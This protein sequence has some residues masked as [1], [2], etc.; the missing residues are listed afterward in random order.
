MMRYRQFDFSGGV[1]SATS[2]LLKKANELVNVR[3]GQFYEEIGS[4]KRR[5]GTSRVGDT[6]GAGGQNT[7]TGG[8]VANFSNGAVRFVAV[9]NSG[10]TATIIR[11][12]N[13]GTG[14]WSTLSGTTIAANAKIFF[15]YYMDEVYITGYESNGNPITPYNVDKTLN[16][17]TTRNILNMPKAHYLAEFNGALYAANV[18][19]GGTRYPDRA[20]KSSGPLGAITFV[21]AAQ[22]GALAYFVVDS[23][24]YIKSGMALDIYTGG[25]DTKIYDITVTSVDKVNNRVYFT[26]INHTFT[27]G[28]V[29]ISTEIITLSSAA[30][31]PTG[32]PIIFSSTGTVPGGLTAGVTYYSIYQSATTIKVAT[33]AANAGLGT[34]IDLTSTGSGTHTVKLS[35]QLKDNDEVWLDGRKGKL[36]IFWNTDFPTP[37]SA[38]WTATLPGTDSS[39]AI[40]AIGKSSNRLFLFTRNSG[41]KYDG[42]NTVT[43]NNSVGCVSQHSLKNIDDDWLVWIDAN[44]KVWARNDTNAQ[45]EFISR[46]IHPTL[47]KYLVAANLSAASAVVF[48]GRYK[49]WL[50]TVNSGYG[51]EKIRVVYS[52]DDNAWTIERH[53]QNILIQATD[54]YTGVEKPYFFSDDGYLY[55]DETGNLD[56]DKVIPLEVETGRDN[57]GSEQ[58]KKY[59]AMLIYSEGAI[60]SSLKI[61][62]DDGDFQTVGHIENSVQYVKFPERGA[63]KPRIGTS[64][65]CKLSS[66]SIGDPQ[67][68]QGIVWYYDIQEDVPGGRR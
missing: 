67:K 43:F 27:T 61:S 2:W 46:Q 31:Y 37:E 18:D 53:S 20:Y 45:Q 23:V 52:F 1:Q 62:I 49:L 7:P 68:I 21:N 56:H 33:T 63:D 6:F 40:T 39:N 34:A 42:V 54:D 47:M 4:I 28:N 64:V 25:T 8:F 14:A 29:N 9:N 65:S 11:T 19:V 58:L 5:L 57:F 41:Q 26:G 35:Y 16:V 48:E 30:D 32:T 17:S 66:G 50:G 3:N 44:G 60:G 51:D 13:S 55:I 10:S 59:D 38:D 36:T 15:F 22:T 12:Q 24:R